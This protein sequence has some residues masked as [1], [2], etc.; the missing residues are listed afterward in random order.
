MEIQEIYK[1]TQRIIEESVGNPADSI[2]LDDT[3]FD[4]L[5]IDSI[6]LVDILFELETTYDIELKISDIEERA[7][8]ELGDNPYEIE[9]II[10][11]EGLKAIQLNMTEL[12][13][14]QLKEGLTVHQLVRLFT[15]HS[16]CKI[17][18]YRLEVKE[19]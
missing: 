18:Q 6:D 5:G 17:V 16:I 10:T 8:A 1:E 19:G 14:T 12:D 7:K 3:L 11:P 9:G 13:T 2:G 15:V 4:G